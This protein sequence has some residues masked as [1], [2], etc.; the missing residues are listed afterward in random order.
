MH[1]YNLCRTFP[2]KG[3]LV[4]VLSRENQ[5]ELCDVRKKVQ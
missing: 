4:S 1:T 2:E 3:F 5:H